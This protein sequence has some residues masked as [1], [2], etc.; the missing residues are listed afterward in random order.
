MEDLIKWEKP[1]K[2]SV[3][4][5]LDE[6]DSR[7][8]PVPKINRSSKYCLE[9]RGRHYPPKYVV[10]RAKKIQG[11]NKPH[12]DGGGPGTNNELR[13]LDPDYVI[14]EDCPSANTCNFAE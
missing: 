12:G 1:T 4:T 5:V 6:I 10:K 14:R 8:R 11:I 9:T 13:N 2:A 3:E 7:S